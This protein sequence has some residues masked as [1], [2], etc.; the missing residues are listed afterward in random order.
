MCG[1]FLLNYDIE[2]IFRKYN[3]RSQ[4]IIKYTKGDF[5][6]GDFYPSS[7]IPIILESEEKI[8]K[9]AKWGFPLIG[10]KGTVINA[11]AE[12]IKHRPMFKN[13]FYS[14]RCLIPVNMFYEWKDEGNKRKTKYKIGLQ[15]NSLFS[16]GGIYKVSIDEN[17]NEQM[18][19]VIITTESEGDMKDI[20]SRMPLIVKDNE[21]DLWLNGSSSIKYVEEILRSNTNYKFVIEKCETEKAKGTDNEKYEQLKLF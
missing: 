10:K 19:V 1:R 12:S 9:L 15:E 7:H 11:R 4:E 5:Y 18:T 20:H 13:S 16:L 8:L 3:I 2:E 21:I 17:S 14:A 6:Q